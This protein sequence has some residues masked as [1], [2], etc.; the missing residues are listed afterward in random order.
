MA[1]LGIPH[2]L[3]PDWKWKEFTRRTE[4][5]NGERL[6][7]WELSA[8]ATINRLL[9]RFGVSVLH[10][11]GAEIVIRVRSIGLRLFRL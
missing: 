9:G 10:T 8:I 5:A 3:D 2:P 1:D 11:R 6:K 4:R 7:R